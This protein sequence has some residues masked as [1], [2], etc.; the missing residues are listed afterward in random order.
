LKHFTSASFFLRLP[1]RP[2]RRAEL[3]GYGYLVSI[4]SVFLLAVPALK[5]AQESTVMA[6]CLVL[7]MTASITGMGLRWVSHLK[8]QSKLREVREEAR[9]NAD[10]GRARAA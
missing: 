6:I 7:G 10:P 5:S 2:K 9:G 3:K 1:Q 8:Q 4:V